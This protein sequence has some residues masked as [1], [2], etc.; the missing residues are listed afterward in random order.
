MLL[1]QRLYCHRNAQ[2]GLA[3]SRGTNAE[4]DIL[5]LDGLD[6]P[7]LHRRFRRYLFLAGRA[8]TRAREI[9]AQTVG[10][11]FGNLGECFAQFPVSELSSFSKE[12]GKILQDLFG[13]SDV[14]RLATH[15]QVMAAG[16]DLNVEQRLEILD[17]LVVNAKKR[18]QSSWWKLY[19]L[20]VVK[21]SP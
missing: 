18:F 13:R 21:L 11:I 19:L 6:V 9:V 4:N 17:V 16:V 20:Q 14:F 2:I 3:S 8:K 1:H 15:G 10:A 12:V 5:L 7:S